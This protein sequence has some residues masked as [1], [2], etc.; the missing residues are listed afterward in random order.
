MQLIHVKLNNGDDIVAYGKVS[1][2]KKS[3]TLKDPVQIVIDPEHGFFA[4]NWLMLSSN[5]V[6]RVPS[7]KIMTIGKASVTAIKYYEEFLR[8]ISS[9]SDDI[10]TNDESIEELEEIFN[11]LLESKSSIKH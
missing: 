10:F 9:K 5:D 2:D 7:N 4:K 6:A 1:D 11:S 3:V 8:R